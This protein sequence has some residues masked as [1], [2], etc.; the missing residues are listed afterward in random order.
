MPPRK[1]GAR[2]KKKSAKWVR[3]YTQPNSRSSSSS[4]LPQVLRYALPFDPQAG[5]K[6]WCVVRVLEA[7]RQTG[8]AAAVRRCTVGFTFKHAVHTAWGRVLSSTKACIPDTYAGMYIW[9]DSTGRRCTRNRGCLLR[10]IVY[11]ALLS[12]SRR[13]SLVHTLK[14]GST[15]SLACT[16]ILSQAPCS[17]PDPAASL[18]GDQARGTFFFSLFFFY[19]FL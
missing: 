9:Y 10:T 12:S 3:P 14:Q 1:I 17:S 7:S 16:G 15:I 18:L 8:T 4:S 2:K 6:S 19:L 5:G 13:Y 11:T